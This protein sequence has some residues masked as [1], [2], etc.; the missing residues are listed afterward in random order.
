MRP[1]LAALRGARARGGGGPGSPGARRPGPAWSTGAQYAVRRGAFF[2]AGLGAAHGAPLARFYP[3]LTERPKPPEAAAPA[4]RAFCL[5]HEKTIA[6]ILKTRVVSTN[7]VL[8]AACLMPAFAE[9]ARRGGQPLHLIE[10]GAS[11]GLLLNWDRYRYDDGYGRVIGAP[12]AALTLV[13]EP[14]GAHAPTLPERRLP[15]LASR[16]GIDPYPLDAA[17]PQDAAWLR[18][19]IWPEQEERAQRLEWALAVARAEPPPIAAGDALERL[20]P[21]LAALPDDGTPCLF[22]AF[23][24]NQFS[25]RAQAAALAGG[26]GM[27]RRPGA[28]T[29][30]DRVPWR[31]ASGD[32][33]RALRAPRRLDR[34]AGGRVRFRRLMRARLRRYN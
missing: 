21:A 2:V 12:E 24:L 16:L 9:A 30:P 3:E 1:C 18:A 17:D 27:G 19:L 10:V 29:A 5:R 14:R 33:A 8:R 20:P 28:G 22:H 11:A 25:A 4:F 23:T 32:D 15:R 26:P 31:G 34:V 7:E 6:Q 13:C